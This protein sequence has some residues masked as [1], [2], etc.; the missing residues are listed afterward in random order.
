[1]Y[2]FGDVCVDLRRLVVTR[3]GEQIGLEPKAF[4]VLRYLLENADRLV[5]KDELMETVWRDTFVTPNVL[6]RAVAQLRRTIGDDAR[7]A[8]YI[9]TVARR[10]YRFIAP[11]VSETPLPVTLQSTAS[12]AV[13]SLPATSPVTAREESRPPAVVAVATAS[14]RG[15]GARLAAGMV[16]AAATGGVVLLARLPAVPPV[17]RKRFACDLFRNLEREPETIRR[18]IQ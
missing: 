2:R 16:L 12:P 9:E 1:M 5:T 13:A 11:V 6:T 15:I 3:A 4:D 17:R 14:A 7:E 8:R 18:L 10:G